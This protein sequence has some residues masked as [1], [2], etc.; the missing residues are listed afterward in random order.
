DILAIELA[1]DV[2]RGIDLGHYGV[3]LRREAPTPHLVAHAWSNGR[4]VWL[5][6]S[7]GRSENETSTVC[8]SMMTDSDTTPA[9]PRRRRLT[10][11][12]AT[13]IAVLGLAAVYGIA[14]FPGNAGDAACAGALATA[15]RIAPLAR[16]EVAAVDVTD[17]AEQVPPLAFKD[18]SG[19]DK[20]LA[21][22]KGR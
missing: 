12:A 9:A 15:K 2:D 10:L 1:V 14:G 7:P 6:G 20:T 21:D 22:W 11:I 5:R 18:A 4:R 19:A 3:G 13:A 17:T 16:G 8:S